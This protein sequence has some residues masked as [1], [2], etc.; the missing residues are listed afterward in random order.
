[1]SMDCRDLKNDQQFR[2]NCSVADCDYKAQPAT[3]MCFAHSHGRNPVM[4]FEQY[5]EECKKPLGMRRNALGE[6]VTEF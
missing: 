5:L 4:T 2:P 3:G 6:I 1:M